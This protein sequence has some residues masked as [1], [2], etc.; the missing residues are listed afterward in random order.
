[1]HKNLLLNLQKKKKGSDHQGLEIAPVAFKRRDAGKYNY[2]RPRVTLA[3]PF[4]SI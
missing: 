1:M 2:A 3:F 4:H